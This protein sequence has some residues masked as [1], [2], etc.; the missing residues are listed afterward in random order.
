MTALPPVAA[1]AATAALDALPPRLRKR[2]DGAVAA[3]AGRAVSGDGSQ[4]RVEVD[5]ENAVV[6]TLTGGIVVGADDVTCSCLL[7]PACLHRAAV[8]AS[9]PLAEKAAEEEKEEPA[10]PAEAE[11][12]PDGGG[13]TLGDEGREAARALWAAGA[14][15]VEAGTGGA[16]AVRR[17][18]LL[19]AAH[20]ARLAGLPGPA[21]LALA[22]ARQVSGARSQ[23]PAFRLPVLAAGLAALLDAARAL[24]EA[25]PDADVGA[26]AGTARRAYR[27]GGTL[28]LYGLFAEPVVTDSG[29]AGAVAFAVAADGT[30]HTVA[31]VLPGGPERALGAAGSPVPGGCALSLRELGA[32]AGLLVDGATVSA[33]G[34]VGGGGGVR[35]VRARRTGWHEAPLAALWDRPPGEQ[36]R[37]VLGWWDLP[38][39]RRPAGGDLVFLDGTL[40]DAGGGPA[41][42]VRDGGP[43]VRLHAADQ[44][45][46]LPYVANLR[47]LS[48]CAGLPVR[49]IGRLDQERAGTVAALA[50]CWTGPDGVPV[51]TDLGLRALTR[52]ALPAAAAVPGVAGPSAV[53]PPVEL[54]LLRRAVTR[55]VEG[56]RAV[57]AAAAD[58]GLPVRLRSAGLVTG[59]SCAAALAAAATDRGHDVLGRLLPG[60][61]DAFARAWLATALYTTAASRSLLAAGWSGD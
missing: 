52:S 58:P 34:R 20:G 12:A 59:A 13:M 33:D 29:Y 32:G 26:L 61:T 44:R 24:T 11:P 55:A 17:T 19:R 30:R 5:D 9:A 35:T 21:A 1:E 42:A 18:A 6:L 51:R 28:R 37:D 10:T 7:A 27:S 4:V 38:E 60:D 53:A 43:V 23:D 50:V 48:G 45:P 39:D 41:L 36:V 3:L 25:D 14:A 31:D 16:G 40:L 49:L 2:L 46:E 8:L 54:D 57:T 47:L 22:V 15:I 56:G